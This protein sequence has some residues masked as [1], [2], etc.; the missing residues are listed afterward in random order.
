MGLQVVLEPGCQI[1][2]PVQGQGQARCHGMAPEFFQQMGMGGQCPVN[3][4][5]V[6][7]PTRSHSRLMVAGQEQDRADIFFGQFGCGN[8]QHTRVPVFV[9]QHQQPL[10]KQGRVVTDTAFNFNDDFLFYGLAPDIEIIQQERDF[11]RVRQGLAGEKGDTDAGVGHAAGCIDPGYHLEGD[12]I[13]I[14]AIHINAGG[15][16]QGL[17]TGPGVCL[18]LTDTGHAQ[19]PVFVD[20]RHH[21]SDGAHGK[22][23]QKRHQLRF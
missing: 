10:F 16:C 14:Q 1:V 8:T 3:V 17:N 21:V 11:F 2:E 19:H 7:A 12:I 18:H 13:G 6:D 22:Q 9:P 15:F 20:Q 4:D 23:I 5:V